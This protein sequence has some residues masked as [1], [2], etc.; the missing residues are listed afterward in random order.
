MLADGVVFRVSVLDTAKPRS[1]H[2]DK[3]P[4]HDNHGNGERKEPARRHLGQLRAITPGTVCGA[5]EDKA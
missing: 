4:R 2:R 3:G 1:D 5:T